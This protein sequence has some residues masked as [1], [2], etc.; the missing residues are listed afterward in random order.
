RIDR[1]DSRRMIHGPATCWPRKTPVNIGEISRSLHSLQDTFIRNGQSPNLRRSGK[2][3]L[4]SDL[5]VARRSGTGYAACLINPRGQGEEVHVESSRVRVARSGLH[6]GGGWWW[7]SRY[8]PERGAGAGRSAVGAA[9]GRGTEYDSF[10]VRIGDT[11][12]DAC[13]KAGRG[14]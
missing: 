4:S 7:L 13:G 9:F 10:D 12:S 14:N 3:S 2:L 6:F 8:P 11:H 5:R 1:M